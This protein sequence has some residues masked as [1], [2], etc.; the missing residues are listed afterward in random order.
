MLGFEHYGKRILRGADLAFTDPREKLKAPAESLYKIVDPK[1]KTYKRAE[2]F[3]GLV[4][5]SFPESFWEKHGI[6]EY[7]RDYS[8]LPIDEQKYRLSHRVGSGNQCDCFLLESL[9]QPEG[10]DR[11]L[12]LKAFQNGGNS[13]SELKKKGAQV[14]QDY[15][16]LREWYKEMPDLIPDQ[17]PVIMGKFQIPHGHPMLAVVQKFLGN[18]IQDV[19][20]GFTDEAWSKVCN[21]NPALR[22]ELKKFYEITQHDVDQY[23]KVPDLL[24]QDNLAVAWRQDTPRL[25]FLDPDGIDRIADMESKT[26]KKVNDRLDLLRRRSGS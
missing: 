18:R 4:R 1:G 17:W 10:E 13:V 5:Q 16:I 23:G 26:V 6:Q 12:V 21:E 7:F 19:A 25:V 8:E 15:E 22:E 2:A 9:H 11:S 24:G 3:F 14:K 20:S